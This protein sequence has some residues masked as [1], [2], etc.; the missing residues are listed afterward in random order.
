MKKKV[1]KGLDD[2]INDVSNVFQKEEEVKKINKRE[3]KIKGNPNEQEII[4]QEN[5][6]VHKPIASNRQTLNT[7][8]DIFNMLNDIQKGTCTQTNAKRKNPVQGENNIQQ[9]IKPINILGIIEPTKLD[10]EPPEGI[11]KKAKTLSLKINTKDIKPS[12]DSKPS[13]VKDKISEENKTGSIPKEDNVLNKLSISQPKDSQFKFINDTTN[14]STTEFVNLIFDIN[15]KEQEKN[16]NK[17]ISIINNLRFIYGNS[18]KTE[19]AS[20]KE[21]KSRF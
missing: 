20:E 6:I 16:L 15:M 10:N 7:E 14:N 5:I 11:L 12:T 4:E 13:T 21:T 9:N 2:L 8:F 17:K 1:K 3:R 18:R 19:Y